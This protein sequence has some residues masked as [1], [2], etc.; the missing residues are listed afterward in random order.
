MPPAPFSG[1]LVWLS[2]QPMHR[3]CVTH[4]GTHNTTITCGEPVSGLRP[5]SILAYWT[6]NANPAWRFGQERGA[7]IAVGGRRGKW[8]VQTDTAQA[9][10][11]GET[12]VITVVVPTPGS[13]DSWYEL[14]SFLRGPD[15]ARLEAQVKTLLQS[16]HW[17]S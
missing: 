2:P 14:T 5:N 13:R 1:W 6:S 15:T 7:Q 16:V 9:P 10:S 8:L 12:E 3:P 17:H 11:L 4:H